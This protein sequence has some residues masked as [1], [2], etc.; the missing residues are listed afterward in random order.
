MPL[1][2]NFWFNIIVITFS[3]NNYEL[4]YHN[5]DFSSSK[6]DFICHNIYIYVSYDF[7]M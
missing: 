5:F 1:I 3:C 2:V 6:Y 7:L 4:V